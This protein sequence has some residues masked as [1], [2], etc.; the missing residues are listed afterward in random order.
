MPTVS[1]QEK[2]ITQYSL[3]FHFIFW[4]GVTPSQKLQVIPISVFKDYACE[5]RE[6]HSITGI[7][8]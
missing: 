7:K 5:L 6:T 4:F 1:L 3:E 8:S 2:T